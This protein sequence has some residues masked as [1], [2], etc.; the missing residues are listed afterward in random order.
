MERFGDAI[1]EDKQVWLLS[2]LDAGEAANRANAMHTA[3]TSYGPHGYWEKVLEFSQKDVDAPEAYSSSY[4]MA[5]LFT[6]LG[7]ND[8]A[9]ESLELAFTQRQLAM[10]EIAIEPAF[11][12]LRSN[13]RFVTMLRRVGVGKPP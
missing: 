12:P 8:R 5:I 3:L 1:D 10:T 2:G 11:D 4:G 7:Q 13:A 6:R 9:V